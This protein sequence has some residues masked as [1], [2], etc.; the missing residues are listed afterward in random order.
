MEAETEGQKDR[1]KQAVLK[2]SKNQNNQN[3]I[4]GNKKNETGL[5]RRKTLSGR[6]KNQDKSIPR[7]KSQQNRSFDI[8]AFA[9]VT[10]ILLGHG[11]PLT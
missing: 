5:R 9:D 3:G 1:K 8:T 4:K 7:G 10:Q 2:I 6:M 11:I